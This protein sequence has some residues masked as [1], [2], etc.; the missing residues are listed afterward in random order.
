MKSR[1]QHEDGD[2]IRTSLIKRGT[3]TLTVESERY[4]PPDSVRPRPSVPSSDH[5]GTSCK[6]HP[7]ST[8]DQLCLYGNRSKTCLE[9]M[10]ERLT[11]PSPSAMPWSVQ[12]LRLPF[13][14]GGR[15]PLRA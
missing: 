2:D 13:G 5:L 11:R 7:Q 3:V 14:S 4:I 10:R 12:L 15:R 9:T 8:S 6:M 1:I